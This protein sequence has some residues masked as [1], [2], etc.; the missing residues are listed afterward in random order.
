MKSWILAIGIFLFGAGLA[1]TGSCKSGPPVDADG[2]V[3]TSSTS[4]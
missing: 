4:E 2:P 1:L 3:A